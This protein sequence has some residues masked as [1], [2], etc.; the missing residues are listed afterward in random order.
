MN[1]VSELQKTEDSAEGNDHMRNSKVN[2]LI[3]PVSIHREIWLAKIIHH[4]QIGSETNKSTGRWF[5]MH[6]YVQGYIFQKLS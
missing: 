3:T 4:N 5:W 1:K 2:S 6:T